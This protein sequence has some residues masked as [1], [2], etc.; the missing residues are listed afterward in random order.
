MDLVGKNM[1]RKRTREVLL[2]HGNEVRH[3]ILLVLRSI[4][5]IYR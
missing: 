3:D 2:K 1:A 5:A 4:T